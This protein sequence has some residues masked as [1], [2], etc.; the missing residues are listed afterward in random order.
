[1]ALG[2][3]INYFRRKSN[4]TMNYLGRLLGFSKS[5]ADARI[6]QYENDSKRPKDDLIKKFAEVFGVSP[7]ALNV[8]DIDTED[9][10]MHTLFALEDI[11]GIYAGR[12]DGEVCLRLNKYVT[13]PGDV[14]WNSIE[15]WADMKEALTKGKI[16]LE[17][18]DDW[19]YNFPRGQ[20]S[21]LRVP[22]ISKE[23]SDALI[24]EMRAE[25]ARE[26][27]GAR[28][29]KTRKNFHRKGLPETDP[30]SDYEE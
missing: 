22:V 27:K 8:P 12:I 20:K 14:I 5:T 3:R 30:D 13:K 23:L 19:R 21:V 29:R 26:Q 16:T 6:A 9:G 17:E 24:K 28:K 4:M 1:M 25:E 2:E 7:R 11:Y 15:E 18:Y 10:L